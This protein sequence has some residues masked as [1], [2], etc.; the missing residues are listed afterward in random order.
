MFFLHW[1]TTPTHTPSKVSYWILTNPM[2]SKY[3]K[4]FSSHLGHWS[5]QSSNTHLRLTNLFSL[6]WATMM[7]SGCSDL[8]F[9]S[10]AKEHPALWR[11]APATSVG[12]AFEELPFRQNQKKSRFLVDSSILQRFGGRFDSSTLEHPKTQKNSAKSAS[13][14]FFASEMHLVNIANVSEN[15]NDSQG[16]QCPNG[17]MGEKNFRCRA[18]KKVVQTQKKGVFGSVGTFWKPKYLR[19]FFG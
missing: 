19:S 12:R 16:L 1:V 7:C 4:H 6:G 17:W 10:A 15:F 18:G 11:S 14:H 5:C 8:A 9:F 13:S 2:T 3:F